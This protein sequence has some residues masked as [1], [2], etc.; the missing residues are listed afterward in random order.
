MKNVRNMLLVLAAI[1]GCGLVV[2]DHYRTTIALDR[3]ENESFYVTAEAKDIIEAQKAIEFATVSQEVV[4]IQTQRVVK[5]EA[6][7]DRY[8]AAYVELNAQAERLNA[9]VESAAEQIKDLVEDNSKLEAELDASSAELEA[10]TTE[11]ER[12]KQLMEVQALELK[13]ALEKLAELA[14]PDTAPAPE[15]TPQTSVWP[16]PNTKVL[17]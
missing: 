3:L 17:Q 6:M 15:T 10:A 14:K 12:V 1:L 9:A 8:A 4:K 13:T 7:L 16:A 5:L 2:L 11:L